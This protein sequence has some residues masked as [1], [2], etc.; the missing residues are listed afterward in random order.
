MANFDVLTLYATPQLPPLER[1]AISTTSTLSFPGLDEFFAEER[2]A[3]AT[4][5][6]QQ[7][8]Q[9]PQSTQRDNNAPR[10]RAATLERRTSELDVQ[11]DES[12]F[13]RAL[14][15][16]KPSEEAA[17]IHTYLSSVLNDKANPFGQ[18]RLSRDKTK[19]LNVAK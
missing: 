19:S 4:L 11:Q 6:E 12:A 7:A 5:Q 16:A 9:Q 17:L 3:Q 13:M 18:V 1:D 10:A 8:H 2:R 15:H 14:A